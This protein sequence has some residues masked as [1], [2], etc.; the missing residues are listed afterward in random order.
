MTLFESNDNIDIEN[1]KLNCNECF[2]RQGCN[3][4][5]DQ[6]PCDKGR[7]YSLIQS[8]CG[9]YFLKKT[10]EDFDEYL[11]NLLTNEEPKVILVDK[12]KNYSSYNTL[13]NY[14]NLILNE[15][16][17]FLEDI[18][19]IY[20]TYSNYEYISRSI[21]NYTLP[22]RELT[23]LNRIYLFLNRV[24]LLVITEVSDN[25]SKYFNKLVDLINNRLMS[26]FNSILFLSKS[27]ISSDLSNYNKLNKFYLIRD[28]NNII[29]KEINKE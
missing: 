13:C 21:Y 17:N 10:N 4:Y 9:V 26:G 29:N 27:Q 11:N 16:P 20:L 1:I 25:E 8:R 24:D 19:V 15:T 5:I 6:L 3:N 12:N 22:E 2:L 7:I 18:K 23:I 14:I 28:K